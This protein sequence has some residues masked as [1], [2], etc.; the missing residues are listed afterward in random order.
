MFQVLSAI[1]EL[2]LLELLCGCFKAAPEKHKYHIFQLMFGNRGDELANTLLT[3]M[4]SMALSVSC[5]S[6]L[7]CA[8]IWMQVWIVDHRAAKSKKERMR[9][10]ERLNGNQRERKGEERQRESE[11][12]RDRDGVARFLI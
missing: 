11:L 6:V 1:E 8:A 12:I 10:R 3:K 7:D 9:W 2:Q 4:V 5:T